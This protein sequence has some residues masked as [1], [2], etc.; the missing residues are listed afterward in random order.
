MNK[1]KAVIFDFDGTFIDSGEGIRNCVEYALKKH[2]I[3]VGDKGKLNY[4][5][6]PPLN[7]GFSDMYGASP[8]QCE[9]LIA[10]YRDRYEKIGVYEAQIYNG[11][12]ELVKK[13]KKNGVKVGVASSKPTYFINKILTHM[14]LTDLFD[15]VVGTQLDNHNADKTILINTALENLQITDKESCIM[16]GDRLYD[17]NGAK[18]AGILSVGVLYGYGSKAELEEAGAD[19]LAQDVTQLN[20]ILLNI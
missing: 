8:K 6:G 16:V 20:K 18:G 19:F 2:N 12:V 1:F 3:P 15:T 17:V 5:I 9:N 4:F 7:V 10:D 14:S 13:L 11:M